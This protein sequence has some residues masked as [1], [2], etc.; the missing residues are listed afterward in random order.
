MINNLSKLVIENGGELK[1]LLVSA[2]DSGGMGLCNPS[3]LINNGKILVNIRNVH[4]TLHHNERQQKFQCAWSGPL[5]YLNPEDDITLTSRNFLCE[6]DDKTFEIKTYNKINTDKLD[7]KP[8]WEFV[9]LE[10]VRLTNWD[11]K[12]YAIGVRRDTETDGK[13]R[14][15]YSTI[16]NNK[17][18]DRKRIE[19]PVDTYLEKNWMPILDMP[20][21]FIKWTNPLEIVKVNLETKTSELILV[22]PIDHKVPLN[23]RGGSQ[24]I[25][26][27]EN[28]IGLMHTVY[29][30][31]NPQNNKDARYTH[32]F[33][34]WDK[35]WNV[36]NV[37]EEF[38][39]MSALI[40]FSC[41][42]AIHNDEILVTFGFQDNA[43]YLLKIP[44][45]YFNKILKRI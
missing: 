40:E 1:P 37:S 39:F 27:G 4:Y 22:K 18:I 14:M 30:M 26:Y 42:M 43:A 41:G 24:I 32:Q 44:N 21:H 28:R 34:V 19:A 2:K 38:N 45:N 9:G 6:L 15:E 29:F 35:D 11:N 33:V 10:D 8:V 23:L 16:H 13:G 31:S 12:L 20:H 25:K 17:E 5:Q 36:I 3:I 7:V